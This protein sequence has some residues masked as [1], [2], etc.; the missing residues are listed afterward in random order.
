MY[1]VLCKEEF[2]CNSL[3]KNGASCQIT[4]FHALCI[5]YGVTPP[6]KINRVIEEPMEEP[7]EEP[8]E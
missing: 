4:N 7:M 6:L 8:I 1:C 3:S 5:G 2:C